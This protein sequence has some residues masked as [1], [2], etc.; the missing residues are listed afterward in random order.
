LLHQLLYHNHY[1]LHCRNQDDIKTLWDCYR[2]KT[3]I[4]LKTKEIRE[5]INHKI[6]VNVAYEVTKFHKGY[7]FGEPIQYVRRE[8]SKAEEPDDA[9]AADI[10]SLN[11]FMALANKPAVD[12]SLAEWMYVAGVGYRLTLPNT[13]WTPDGDE[14]PFSIYVLDPARTFIVHSTDMV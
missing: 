3:K 2:G 13:K 8:R 5:E 9:I 14:A 12:N 10:N 1:S 4:L 11:G 7:V 6:N